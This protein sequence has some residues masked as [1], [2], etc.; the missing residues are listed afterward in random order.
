M[1]YFI[2]FFIILIFYLINYLFKK[3]NIESF[4]KIPPYNPQGSPNDKNISFTFKTQE[5]IETS[6]CN[7]YWKKW[8]LESN[9][10]LVEQL[11]LPIKL[12]Q[13]NLPKDK[14]FANNN[15]IQGFI[16][17]TKLA[18]IS[19]DKINYNIFQ[20]SSE[21]IIDPLTKEKLKYKYELEFK[22]YQLNEKTNVNRIKEYN[23]ILNVKFYYN[24][25]KSPI[26][27]INKLNFIFI[28][29]I[30]NNQR[31]VL[32]KDELILYGIIQNQIFKYKIIGI[33]YLNNEIDRPVYIMEIT[34]FTNN[35]YYFNTFSYVGFFENNKPVI[36]NIE[37]VGKNTTDQFLINDGYDK[38]TL[39]QEI[40]NSNF[41]NKETIDRD[42]NA[43]LNLRKK[44]LSSFKLKNQYACFD[45]NFDETKDFSNLLPYTTKESCESSF[46]FYGRPKKVGIFDTPC[47]KDEDCPFFKANKNYENNYGKCQ[48][49]GYCELPVNMKR[50]GYRYFSSNNS[51]S[52][53]CYNCD[54][55]KFFI[56][57]DLNNCCDK[58]Q[59]D[60]KYSFLKSPDYVFNDDI[61][62]RKNYFQKKFCKEKL[63]TNILDCEEYK[64]I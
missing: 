2:I 41:S 16:D 35:N 43:I 9:N 48:S 30:N 61:L 7:K 20:K 4:C 5:S 49:D 50:I 56:N 11:P 1:K 19:S 42:P 14:Q 63:G 37:Y 52:P 45:M 36:I 33:N 27:N 13:L 62:E 64:I 17:Y 53:L 31:F 32:S 12:D 3:K 29:K 26:E 55:N 21:L 60:K 44:Y 51:D 57:T 46:D 54:T 39:K 40:I 34:I 10:T 6:S 25:I 23:P 58:Q 22:I 15:Y 47:K 18:K 8:P 59:F 38:D 24:E 28:E